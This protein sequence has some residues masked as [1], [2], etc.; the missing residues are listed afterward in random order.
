MHHFTLPRPYPNGFSWK[1]LESIFRL[2]D[3]LRLPV[4]LLGLNALF[5]PNTRRLTEREIALAQSVFGNTIDYQK[6]RIDERSRIG[7]KRYHFAYVSFNLINCWAPLSDPLLI[8]ELVHI[9]Q[10]QH[11]ASVY[12]PRALYAQR[13]REGYNY[14]GGEAIRQA[15]AQGLGFLDFNWEQQ[16]DIVADYFCLKQGL[17]PRWCVGN[18]GYLCDFEIVMKNTG[19]LSSII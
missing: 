15:V 4:L 2:F 11:F 3:L 18:P 13:T 10:Y 14:G 9:W 19:G 6:I 17:K 12:I 7:C 8:H 5:K 1:L 16:G